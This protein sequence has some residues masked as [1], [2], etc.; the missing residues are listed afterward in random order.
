MN[1]AWMGTALALL[2]ASGVPAL[3]DVV[4]EGVS[5]LRCT[6]E[7]D[8]GLPRRMELTQTISSEG[9]ASYERTGLLVDVDYNDQSV[10]G[11]KVIATAYRLGADSAQTKLGKLTAR[12]RAGEVE[13][14]RIANVGLRAGDTILWKVRLKN[15]PELDAQREM[16]WE[17]TL[18]VLVAEEIP[19]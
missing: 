17:L 19:D 11:G 12:I 7:N 3:A 1:R 8:I 10:D 18:T 4:G 16:C 6:E 13:K 2:L 14:F 9:F 5:V 15:M